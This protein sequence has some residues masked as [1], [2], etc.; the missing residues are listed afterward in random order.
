MQ[1]PAYLTV[2]LL[3]GILFTT[4]QSG[5]PSHIQQ[6]AGLEDSLIGNWTGTS[7]CEVKNSPCRDEN[8]VFHFAK[9][10]GADH[11]K[12]SADKIVNGQ[13]INMGELDFALNR[14]THTLTCT[15]PSGTWVL[16]VNKWHI[17]GTLT[18]ADKVLFRKLSLTKTG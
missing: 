11:Y 4:S 18:T 10:S 7:K 1:T 13:A 9:G 16:V 6:N 17:D 12:V 15:I 2:L 14:A 5:R 8:V 3:A